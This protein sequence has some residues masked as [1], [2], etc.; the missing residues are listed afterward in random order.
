MKY[1]RIM[2]ALMAECWAMEETKFLAMLDFLEFQFEGG[3]L[4]E[5][6]I[7]AK[8]GKGVERATATT[9]RRYRAYPDPWRVDQPGKSCRS[10]LSAAGAQL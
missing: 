10:E 4:S 5:V 2:A 8:V 6:E 3:K 9:G 7:A 1:P